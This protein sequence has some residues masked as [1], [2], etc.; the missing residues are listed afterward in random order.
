LPTVS[1]VLMALVRLRP[2]APAPPFRIVCP[3]GGPAQEPMPSGEQQMPPWAFWQASGAVRTLELV[4]D[5]LGDVGRSIRDLGE[6]EP[7]LADLRSAYEHEVERRG[8]N[9]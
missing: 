1:E 3:D 4:L 7:A 5:L 8:A 9:W 6:V 2:T